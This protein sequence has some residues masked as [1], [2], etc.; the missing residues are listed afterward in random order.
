MRTDRFVVGIHAKS[1]RA[2][3]DPLPVIDAL[4]PAMAELPGAVLQINVHDEIFDRVQPL[5]RARSSAP[6][7]WRGQGS[8]TWT[9]GS[10]LT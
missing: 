2:N 7:C 5:V 3:M 10:I 4:I 8:Q 9:S 1:L 6:S